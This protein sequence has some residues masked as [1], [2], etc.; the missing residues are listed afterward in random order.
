MADDLNTKIKDDD[1]LEAETEKD[2]VDDEI[3]EDIDPEK[4]DAVEDPD[5]LAE[6]EAPVSPEDDPFGFGA[7]GEVNEDGEEKDT[8]SD[9][10]EDEEDMVSEDLF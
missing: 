5:D 1:E 7:F 10:D 9:D 4:I 8:I 3:E 6:A 2:V